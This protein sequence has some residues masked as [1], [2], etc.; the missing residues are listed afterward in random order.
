MNL[1]SVWMLLMSTHQQDSEFSYYLLKY[2]KIYIRC[3]KEG[4]K[5]KQVS[6]KHRTQ[7]SLY[8][9]RSNRRI[10]LTCLAE[11]QLNV[12]NKNLRR[13]FIG[14]YISIINTRAIKMKAVLII[15]SEHTTNPRTINYERGD[16]L[17]HI[18][19]VEAELHLR[20][21]NRFNFIL[22]TLFIYWRKI[23]RLKIVLL[24]SFTF[25]NVLH[26]EINLTRLCSRKMSL[27]LIQKYTK[28]TTLN[29]IR[30]VNLETFQLH[31]IWGYLL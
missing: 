22:L 18:F 6:V 7:R 15:H 28:L 29:F 17:L 19:H 30:P 23:P 26:H 24:L 4:G 20:F 21:K 1:P 10:K 3:G 25:S 13:N 16:H 14:R 11:L 9:L 8:E 2:R 31:N 27:C 12:S 5:L